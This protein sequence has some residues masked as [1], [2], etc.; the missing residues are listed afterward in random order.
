MHT[1]GM[2]W[3]EKARAF[4]NTLA[5]AGRLARELDVDNRRRLRAASYLHHALIDMGLRNEA[6]FVYQAWCND[7]E[8]K[9]IPPKERK[10]LVSFAQRE[11]S[12]G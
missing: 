12:S 3:N 2:S 10:S 11:S 4:S 8:L 1:R 7:D 6:R 5:K 9:S